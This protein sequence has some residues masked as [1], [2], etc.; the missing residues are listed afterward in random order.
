MKNCKDLFFELKNSLEGEHQKDEHEA[1]S[2]LLLQHVFGISRNDIMLGVPVLWSLDDE[3]KLRDLIGRINEGEPLQ[4]IL[5]EADFF[6]RKFVVNPAVLIPRPETEE[7]VAEAIRRLKGISECRILDIGTGSGCIPI[8]LSL[9]IPGAVVM[10][11]DVSES[12]LATARM[13]VIKHKV[14]VQLLQHDILKSPLP[15]QNLHAILSNPPYITPAE[16]EEMASNVIGF[17]PHIALFV[18]EDEPLLFFKAIISQAKVVLNSGGIILFEVN[19]LFAHEVA[20]ELRE[21]G[22]QDV[23]VLKDLSGKYRVVLGIKL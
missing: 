9:E 4:Y 6:G 22:F 5:G 8:T 20:G 11:T 3:L 10:A 21:N 1:I 7:L 17:E 2:Y 19:P 15:F 12:A 23:D 13:N 16:K 14:P 18:P